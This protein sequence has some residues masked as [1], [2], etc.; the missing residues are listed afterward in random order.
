MKNIK[1]I[2]CT[3]LLISISGSCYGFYGGRPMGMGGAYTAVADDASCAYWNPAGMAL[4]PG[5][6]LIGSTLITNR[7][8][9]IGDNMGALKMCYEAELSS[10]F[11]WVLGVGVVSI[12][13]LE[14]ARVLSDA[15]VLKS[16]WGREGIKTGRDESMSDQVKSGIKPPEPPPPPPPPNKVIVRE[17]VTYM[18]YS[19]WYYPDYHRPTYWDNRYEY[20]DDVLSPRG[21][22]QYALGLTWLYD[23]NTILDQNT[24]W[25]TVTVASGWEERVALGANVN[26]YDLKIP[27]RNTKGFGAGID[28]GFLGRPTENFTLGM[29]IKEILTTDIA[30]QNGASTR[31][32]MMVNIGAALKPIEQVTLAAD[33]HNWFEQNNGIRTFHYGL[34]V[35]PVS[36][37]ALR[38]GLYDNNKTAGASLA[39]GPAI[40]DYTILGGSYG[41]TQMI[42]LTWK[43]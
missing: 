8:E 31:Y 1:A 20:E 7:N 21:K 39:L 36:G 42:G 37:I 22:A 35:R 30:W 25:Y 12:F 19:P 40:V 2:I 28:L 9:R 11:E 27:S 24:N 32:E 43:F 17:S 23:G 16:G 15:G 5:I 4:N 18:W 33:V 41:R 34:E 13:A 14:T 26:F 29:M 3:I 10:P 38:S 6:D